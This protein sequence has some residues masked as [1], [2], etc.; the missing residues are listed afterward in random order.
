[1]SWG[2]RVRDRM[3]DGYTHTCAISAF[4][5]QCCEF[6]CH[7]GDTIL[8]DKVCQ[9][10]TTGRWF[11]PGTPVSSTNKT[12]RHDITEIFS[13]LAL[14]TINQKNKTYTLV[15]YHC[16]LWYMIVLW[17]VPAFQEQKT[18]GYVANPGQFSYPLPKMISP[19]QV[20]SSVCIGAGTIRE[21]GSV[22][23]VDNCITQELE[24]YPVVMIIQLTGCLR[25]PPSLYS[26]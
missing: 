26:L 17:L 15:Q 13:K 22:D 3:V 16:T 23:V 9:W 2:R 7:S 6:E 20:E 5:H 1:M 11:S 18:S 21:L 14:N 25:T 12:D 10:H 4:H 19:L 24:M 8:C